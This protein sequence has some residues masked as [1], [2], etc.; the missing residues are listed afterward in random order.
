LDDAASLYALGMGAQAEVKRRQ[1]LKDA[2]TTGAET[3][4]DRVAEELVDQ[5]NEKVARLVKG[6]AE[7]F[8]QSDE[9]AAS[10]EIKEY[11]QAARSGV[12]F[13]DAVR[14]FSKYMNDELRLI[15]GAF[16]RRVDTDGVANADLPLIEEAIAFYEQNNRTPKTN[17]FMQREEAWLDALNASGNIPK[18]LIKVLRDRADNKAE[19]PDDTK[20][21]SG[22]SAKKLTSEQKTSSGFSV[23]EL[24]QK[25]S[26]RRTTET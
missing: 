23:D 9:T 10:E 13:N 7:K 26:K 12:Q 6:L 3:V 5:G 15:L 4:I 11:E 2:S 21:I 8:I 18:S 22:K 24:K 16:Y 20:A 17:Y 19:E 25:I 14:I 1:D